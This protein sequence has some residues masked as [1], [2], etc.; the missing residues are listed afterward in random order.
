MVNFNITQSWWHFWSI[1]DCCT[2]AHIH[3]PTLTRVSST[4]VPWKVCPKVDAPLPVY[5]V[6]CVV[7]WSSEHFPL[8]MHIISQPRPPP[9]ILLST[10]QATQTQAIRHASPLSKNNLNVFYVLRALDVSI[11]SQ[12]FRWGGMWL[13]RC[14]TDETLRRKLFYFP[15]H[16]FQKLSETC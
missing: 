4:W 9:A 13:K 2:C 7:C 1:V 16:Y 11:N 15:D 10:W 12:L 5:K 14:K 8:N 6:F 3:Q